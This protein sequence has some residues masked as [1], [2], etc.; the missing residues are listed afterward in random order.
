M[1]FGFIIFLLKILLT[2]FYRYKTYGTQSYY[3]GGAIIASN[4]V[5]FLDPPLIGAAWPEKT[6]YLARATL[7]KSFFARSV[8]NNLNAHPVEGTAQDIKSIKTVC[9]LLDEEKKVVI[10][11]EGVRSVDGQMRPIKTGIAMLALRTK[12]PIIPAYIHGAFEI[13]PRFRKWPAWHGQ[14]ACVFGKPIFV[15]SYAHLEK[16]TAQERIAH[17]IKR[18][19][20]NLKK[21]IEN[22]AI[23]EIP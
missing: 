21:W 10:F 12:K 7:F 13:W 2:L 17:D 23:G 4:H 19:I 11:P 6:H 5:S 16:K 18:S 8:L 1:F 3:K 22:G 14:L 15:E 20:E 9:Q